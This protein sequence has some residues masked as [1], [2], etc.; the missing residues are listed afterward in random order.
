MQFFSPS[1][2]RTY[3]GLKLGKFMRLHAQGIIFIVPIREMKQFLHD[4]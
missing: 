4:R 1:F 2:Y 3:E